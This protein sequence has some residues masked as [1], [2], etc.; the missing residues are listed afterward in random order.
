MLD[1]FFCHYVSGEAFTF[2]LGA[3]S[4]IKALNEDDDLSND[5]IQCSFSC[6]KACGYADARGGGGL[7]GSKERGPNKE[8]MFRV[9]ERCWPRGKVVLIWCV[10]GEKAVRTR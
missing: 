6:E 10:E 2:F 8:C 3:R 5:I 7:N 9:R 1:R 4:P